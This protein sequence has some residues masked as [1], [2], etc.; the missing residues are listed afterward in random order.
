MTHAHLNPPTALLRGNWQ[1][2]NL[3]DA[4]RGPSP[5]AELLVLFVSLFPTAALHGRQAT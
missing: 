5:I 4:S 3:R 1:D 2:F